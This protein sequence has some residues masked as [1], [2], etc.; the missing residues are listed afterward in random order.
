[1]EE[2]LEDGEIAFGQGLTLVTVALAA[3]AFALLPALVG[4]AMVL[5]WTVPLEF[6]VGAGLALVAGF[7]VCAG[8]WGMAAASRVPHPAV[9][10]SFIP[11]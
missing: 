1:M 4:L 8:A 3:L 5:G 7:K 9:P 6:G 11:L 10:T 2:S